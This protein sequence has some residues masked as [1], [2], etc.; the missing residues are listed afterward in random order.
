MTAV[1][2][3]TLASWFFDWKFLNNEPWRWLLLLGV[4]LAGFVV[5]KI[6]SFWLARQAGHFGRDERR[7]VLAMLLNSLARPATFLALAGALYIA[8]A[9]MDLD[10][11]GQSLAPMWINI[12]RML[13][14]LAAG[15]FIYRLVDIVEYYLHKLTDK[16][17][18][19]LDDQLVP[20]I[21]KTLRVFVVIVAVL[22]IA[23]NIFQW[24]IG[25]LIAGLGIGG[26]AL[27][28][29]AKDT[30]ANLFGSVT[31]FADRPFQM[32]DRVKIKGY[33]G[34]VEEVGF[35]SVRIRLLNGRLVV[36]PNAMVANETVENISKR[37][38][39]RHDMTVGV[40]YD[41]A[42]DK[43]ERGVEI[44]REMLAERAEAFPP[45][46]PPRVHFTEFDTASLNVAVSYWFAPPD[47]GEYLIF[48][49]EFNMELLRRFND[50]G[51][52]FAFPTQT[53][54]V[55]QE[56]PPARRTA[57]KTP[58][59]EKVARKKRNKT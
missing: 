24:D 7:T 38:F 35:R 26:L 29:A 47:W 54:Y 22:F 36:I 57:K 1:A 59:K 48:T 37:P 3:A 42:P 19:L 56:T 55:K 53:L 11:E 28:L 2:T 20:L 18:T 17:D 52:E 45:D 6:A 15:W 51:I 13:S 32:G 21:R 41:T 44:I 43:F 10:F 23:Q 39:I 30:L 8:Q 40:T 31:I 34:V 4:L 33:D 14:V 25:A 9:F 5:G 46:N 50:E 12:S 49:H 27:A 58:A 16:T